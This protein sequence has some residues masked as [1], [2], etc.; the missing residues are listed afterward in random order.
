MSRYV[1]TII[2][3]V[4]LQKIHTT[5]RTLSMALYV[6]EQPAMAEQNLLRQLDGFDRF[7]EDFC[8][9]KKKIYKTRKNIP[10]QA[11]KLHRQISNMRLKMQMLSRDQKYVDD[12][13]RQLQHALR[14]YE[15][16]RAYET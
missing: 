16:I 2:E 1:L 6:E 9:K 13:L 11:R 15:R 8:G 7:F 12:T 5:F 3:Q 10:K 4:R 14:E